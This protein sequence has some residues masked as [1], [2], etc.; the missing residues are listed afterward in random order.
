MQIDPD[1]LV[2]VVDGRKMLMFRNRGD[3]V[4]PKLEVE[5]AREQDNPATRDQ[6]TDAPGRNLGS[7]GGKGGGMEQTDFHQQAADRFAAD[8][9]ALL[10]T[11]ALT[12]DY[13]KLIVV[14]PP[15]TLGELRK[16]YHKEVQSRLAGE[17]A[18]DLAS[19][20][21]PEIERIIVE[22]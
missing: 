5:E 13:E 17:I 3:D 7:A 10:K 2:M 14:A 11:R 12:N 22:S 19:H 4:Y 20:P 8:A 15:A 18:K 16:H 21:V 1:A 6:G 9:A